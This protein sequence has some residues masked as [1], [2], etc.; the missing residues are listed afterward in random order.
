MLQGKSLREPAYKRFLNASPG[1]QKS[2]V[3]IQR[4]IAIA[5]GVKIVIHH[6]IGHKVFQIL[7]SVP[8]LYSEISCNHGCLESKKKPNSVPGLYSEIS[9]NHGCLE[10]KK[11]PSLSLLLRY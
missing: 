5:H 3:I 2:P 11:N 8:G 10:S 4:I 1:A 6:L 7:N 9:C